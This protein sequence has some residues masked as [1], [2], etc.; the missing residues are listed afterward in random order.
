[1]LQ[2]YYK[3][4]TLVLSSILYYN[5]RNKLYLGYNNQLPETIIYAVSIEN[6]LYFLYN[7]KLQALC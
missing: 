2:I 7:I 4:Q 6:E 1:M 3:I 5:T